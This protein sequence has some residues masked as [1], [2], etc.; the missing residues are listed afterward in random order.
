MSGQ[1]CGKSLAV[2]HNGDLFSCDH[3]VYP[4]YKLGDIH[5][6]HQ[7]DLVFSEQQKKF[8]YA[9]SKSLPE[10]CQKCP[11][12]QYCWGDCPKDRFLKTPDGEA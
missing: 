6:I 11:Y 9:K 12:L 3:F 1:I 10:Y 5:E 2:E 8:A 4:E 7:G